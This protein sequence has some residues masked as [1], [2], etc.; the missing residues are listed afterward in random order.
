[1]LTRARLISILEHA[2]QQDSSFILLQETRHHH[3]LVPWAAKCAYQYGWCIHFSEPPPLDPKGQRRHGGT[4][5]LWQRNAG[6]GKACCQP[7]HCSNANSHR[8]AFVSFPGFI[9]G[10]AYGPAKTCDT[11]WFKDLFYSAFSASKNT[12]LIV[13]D[14]NWSKPYSKIV[15]QNWHI[16]QHLPTTHVGTAPTRALSTCPISQLSACPLPGIPTHLA[17]TYEVDFSD[18]G[19]NININSSNRLKRCASYLWTT[20]FLDKTQCDKIISKVN[21]VCPTVTSGTCTILQ[22]WSN[23]HER[24]ELAFKFAAEFGHAKITSN[25][26]RAKG[27]FPGSRPC[28]PGP[29]QREPQTVLHRRLLRCHRSLA[30]LRRQKYNGDSIVPQTQFDRLNRTLHAANRPT[31]NAKCTLQ[32]AFAA[33]DPLI[34]QLE[35]NKAKALHSAWKIKF[36]QFSQDIWKPAKNFLKA[37]SHSVAFSAEDVRQDWVSHWCPEQNTSE[38]AADSWSLFADE[39]NYPSHSA[40]A[41]TCPELP[42]RQE[43][44]KAM[45]T[46]AGSPG[47][48]GWTAAEIR[49]LQMH[50]TP[51][52]DELYTLWCETSNFCDN[53]SLVHNDVAF[54][55][56]AW[57]VVGIPKKSPTESR[58][59][60]IASI[61]TRTWHRALLSVCPAPPP[62]QWC[63]RKAMSVV[64]ATANF[65]AAEPDHV[66]ETD[67]TKAFDHLWPQ[68]A[69][70]ALLRLGVPRPIVATLKHAWSGPRI[71]TVGGDFAVPI[72]PSRGVPQGDPISPLALAACIGPWSQA[73]ENISPML[74]TWAYMD[75]RTIAVLKGGNRSLL[76]AAIQLTQSF[77]QKVGFQINS[78][79]T[80]NWSKDFSDAN[81]HMEHLGIKYQPSNCK[82]PVF[83]RDPL[84]KQEAVV[85]LSRCPGSID[86]RSKLATAFIQPLQDWASPLIAPGTKAEAKQLFRA[87]T[88]CTSTWWCQARF[89]CQHIELHP[90]LGVALRG[91][92][93]MPRVLND[94]CERVLFLLRI[95]CNALKLQVVHTSADSMVVKTSSQQLFCGRAFGSHDADFAQNTHITLAHSGDDKSIRHAL[96]VRARKMLLSQVNLT[97]FDAEGIDQVDLD[98][99][100]HKHW[101]KFLKTLT[102]DQLKSLTIWRS[103]A[104]WTPTRR[105]WRPN[106]PNTHTSCFWCSCSV[107]SARHFFCDCPKF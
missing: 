76:N 7:N 98:V 83:P 45:L 22:K 2:I 13:G 58:P 23:W 81:L 63:G 91:I 50:L 51:I 78:E 4:A 84:K 39:T 42:S 30:E 52:A 75:D 61:L 89:W 44:W 31:F 6:F 33:L 92:C 80:Q 26:E 38:L 56:W 60:S 34:A 3:K 99:H 11:S 94:S 100:S 21:Q 82:S 54:S 41:P 88:H 105:F 62:G 29:A 36:R 15:P 17:T 24:A 48:D 1:M 16:A 73:V 65:F 74:R 46:A 71:C 72:L 5:V 70:K 66:A 27:S 101:K 64:H 102:P 104:V 57:K 43:F 35:Q 28:A 103:G 40:I 69:C 97:R 107:A 53:N 95:H 85:R 90:V 9:V 18:L 67:L 25:A 37:P 59:L 14:F 106:A 19:Q 87:I 49:A 86:V 79:K 12:Q 93:N 55:L 77:D 10:S 8:A 47:F 68:V 96:R 32:A 20:D